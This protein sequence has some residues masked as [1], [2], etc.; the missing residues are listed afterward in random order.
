MNIRL[1]YILVTLLTVCLTTCKKYHDGG[2]HYNAFNHLEGQWKLKLYEVDRIDSTL[3]T[4]GATTIPDY[5]EK[6]AYFPMM[7]NGKR[8]EIRLINHHR[9]YE[10]T[11]GNKKRSIISVTNINNSNFDFSGCLLY[12]S[13]E[14]QRDVFNPT[15]DRYFNWK[16]D[17]LTKDELILVSLSYN[18]KLILVK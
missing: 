1:K 16:I 18:Y 8:R 9:H 10:V 3:L 7:H 2:Y 11:M 5:L 15:S 14:C 4:Q 17:K 6:F 13:Q 12:N